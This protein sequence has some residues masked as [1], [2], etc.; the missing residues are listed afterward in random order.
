MLQSPSP[1]LFSHTW[2]ARGAWK[3]WNWPGTY[4]ISHQLL[5]CA[6][7]SPQ[8]TESRTPLTGIRVHSCSLTC[9][10]GIITIRKTGL[11]L[12]TVLCA[13]PRS[14][15]RCICPVISGSSQLRG[16]PLTF[17][18]FCCT[19]IIPACWDLTL[20]PRAHQRWNGH[21][22]K[23]ED[24]RCTKIET[25]MEHAFVEQWKHADLVGDG[26]PGWF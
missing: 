12:C 19:R 9:R 21:T 6:S 16:P 17:A 13:V 3:M 26:C 23:S 1:V 2:W 8:P 11:S 25:N 4:H 10:T 20:L 15:A 5:V 24:G 18:P 14:L 7:G 22:W